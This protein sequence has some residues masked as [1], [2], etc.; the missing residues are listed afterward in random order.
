MGLSVARSYLLVLMILLT[1]FSVLALIE[2]LEDLGKGRYRL[3]DIVAF[4]ALTMPR[5]ALDL[6]PVAA[7]LGSVVALGGLAS[8]G[9]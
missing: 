7:L 4:I 2:E 9:E 5:R 8:A 6:S 1:L 3:G